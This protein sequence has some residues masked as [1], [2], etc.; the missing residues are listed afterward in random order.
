MGYKCVINTMR[1]RIKMLLPTTSHFHMVSNIHGFRYPGATLSEQ[2]AR[3][4][5]LQHT[6]VRMHRGKEASSGLWMGGG[7][8]G[9]LD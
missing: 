2:G 4:G 3:G 9:L 1:Q 5:S 7:W 6:T 8:G